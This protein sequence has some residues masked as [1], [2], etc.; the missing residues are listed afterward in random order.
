MNDDSP[1]IEQ[2]AKGTAIA[3]AAGPGAKAFV[4]FGVPIEIWLIAYLVAAILTQGFGYFCSL[5][6]AEPAFCIFGFGLC[7]PVVFGIPAL[8]G[9]IFG[10]SVK[11]KRI[12]R[13]SLLSGALSL[14]IFAPLYSCSSLLKLIE[15][16]GS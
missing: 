8:F 1:Q 14:L 12:I 15:W 2:N 3:Q 10:I 13:L 7:F 16:L 4:I 11:N 9:L 6:T 5:G